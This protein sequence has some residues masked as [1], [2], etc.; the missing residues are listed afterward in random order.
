MKTITIT[1]ENF[2]ENTK[3]VSMIHNNK[4]LMVG[5]IESFEK[6]ANN[7]YKIIINQITCLLDATYDNLVKTLIECRYSLDEELSIWRKQTIE[8]DLF[9]EHEI[10]V[11]AVKNYAKNILNLN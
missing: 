7:Y 3:F 4:I 2:N 8:P 10:Y 5:S 9:N 1:E 6:L 11:L